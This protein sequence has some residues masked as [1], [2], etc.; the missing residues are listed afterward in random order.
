MIIVDPISDILFESEEIFA[1][2]TIS[3][4]G[5]NGESVHVNMLDIPIDFKLSAAYPNPFNPSTT[6]EFTL[7]LETEVSIMVYNLKGQVISTLVNDIM[8]MGYYS[9]V[10]DARQYSSGVYFVQFVAGEF[11]NTQ[12]LMLI[13]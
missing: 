4:I 12:K 2:E 13:K 5:I 6:L 1:I 8:S 3:A 9:I 11:S 10:W 7:P